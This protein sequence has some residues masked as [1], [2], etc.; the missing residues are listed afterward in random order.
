M[1]SYI[2]FA[3]GGSTGTLTTGTTTGN[4]TF[5]SPSGVSFEYK[6]QNGISPILY[7]K[8]VKSKFK[9]LERARLDKRL[10]SIERAFDE[11]VENGQDALAQK[12]LSE[13]VI[14][15]RESVI[16]AKGVT[17]YIDRDDAMK[18][19]RKIN[20]GHISDTMLKDFTRV[21]PKD[22][23]KKKRA[24]ESAFDDFVIFHYYNDDQK[25]LKDLT[26][27]EKNKMRD[28]I[29]FG[30]IKETNRLYF[31]ADWEDEFCDLTFNEMVDVIGKD[32]TGTLKS[33]YHRQSVD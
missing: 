24:V 4:W 23:I 16:F 18:F 12:I 19:K 26:P 14:A 9:L 21:I 27:D 1:N 20:G 7:F 22:V 29:L 17:K 28:P 15:S 13:L 11:S 10:K 31:I 5:S 33:K 25:D 2:T 32:K 6:K 30:I 3:N 8:F